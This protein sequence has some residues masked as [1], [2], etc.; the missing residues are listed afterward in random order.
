VA[1]AGI[2][3][4]LAITRAHAAIELERA[5]NAGRVEVRVAHVTGEP[6]RRKVYR[7][8]RKGAGL[9]QTVRQRALRRT[10][11]LVR[12][13]GRPEALSGRQALDVLRSAGVGEGRAVLLV[14][15]RRH[16]DLRRPGTRRPIPPSER[17]V[18]TAENRMRDSFE[19]AF[20]RPVAWQFEVVL[21]PPH[22][23]P[24]PVGA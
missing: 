10:V 6:T 21:G 17:E 20:V 11:E 13:D 9:A 3:D 12:H 23:P 8:T 4:S 1:Q 18:T 15:T 22:A 24:L 14:L 19:R 2:A 5:L 7:L 16:I